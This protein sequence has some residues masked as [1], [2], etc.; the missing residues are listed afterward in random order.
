ML[1]GKFAIRRAAGKAWAVVGSEN[2]ARTSSD[3]CWPAQLPRF[4]RTRAL[5]LPPLT[6]VAVVADLVLEYA[7][8]AP[9]KHAVGCSLHVPCD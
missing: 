8:E 9:P 3:T 7:A 6:N 4:Q 5:L 2:G 1:E